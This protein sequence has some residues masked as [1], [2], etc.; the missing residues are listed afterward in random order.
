MAKVTKKKAVAKKT[1][2]KV[3]KKT[4]KKSTKKTA[5]E[6]R[7]DINLRKQMK[8]ITA[9]SVE[10]RKTVKAYLVI[11][12]SSDGGPVPISFATK[13]DRDGFLDLLDE[14]DQVYSFTTEKITID[15]SE[16]GDCMDQ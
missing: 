7:K 8:L 5:K 1:M 10:V 12:E 9:Q 13:K 6:S 16:S 4:T 2:K 14:N 3:A 11:V 15:V